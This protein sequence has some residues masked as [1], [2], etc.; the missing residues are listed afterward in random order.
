[1]NGL[2]VV[3]ATAVWAWLLGLALLAQD[4][5]R[6]RATV[7]AQPAALV[8]YGLLAACAAAACPLWWLNA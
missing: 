7:R 8:G 1:M 3:L 6:L 4:W 5:R 2:A